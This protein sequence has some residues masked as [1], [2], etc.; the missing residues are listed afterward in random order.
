[1]LPV[2][3]PAVAVYIASCRAHTHGVDRLLFPTKKD[4]RKVERGKRGKSFFR[5][6]APAPTPIVLL[7][8]SHGLGLPWCLFCSLKQRLQYECPSGPTP[9]LH[10]PQVFG[11]LCSLCQR[12]CVRIP[13]SERMQ[14]TQ[15]RRWPALDGEYSTDPPV[16]FENEICYLFCLFSWCLGGHQVRARRVGSMQESCGPVPERRSGHHHQLCID[17]LQRT[18][19]GLSRQVL[20]VYEVSGDD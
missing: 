8:L 7:N 14:G 12:V 19:S 18:R 17:F 6:T 20:I 4:L 9:L 11:C 10:M 3:P 13:T 5:L 15:K 16:Y 1:M 2:W